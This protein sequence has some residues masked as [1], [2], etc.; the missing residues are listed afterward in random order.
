[1][2]ASDVPAHPNPPDSR[3]ALPALARRA[4]HGR[5]IDARR[6]RAAATADGGRDVSYFGMMEGWV[7]RAI[8]RGRIQ[9]NLRDVG[10]GF[11]RGRVFSGICPATD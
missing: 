9:F 6:W 4:A 1:M 11:R 5:D 8:L 7:G 2:I 10:G 3:Q